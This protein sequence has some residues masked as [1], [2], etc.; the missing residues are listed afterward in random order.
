MTVDSIKM[1][2]DRG[3][4]TKCDT[5]LFK[6]RP[7]EHKGVMLQ[8]KYDSPDNLVYGLKN[9]ILD[10]LSGRFE[11]ELSAKILGVDYINNINENNIERVFDIINKTGIIGINTSRIAD[12]GVLRV[13]VCDNVHVDKT[14]EKYFKALSLYKFNEKYICN[15]NHKGSVIFE[16][17]RKKSPD[18]LTLYD[19]KTELRES[20][21]KPLLEML[22]ESGRLNEFDDVIRIEQ[23]VRSFEAMR[24][25]IGVK[26]TIE[27]GALLIDILQSKKRC[28]RD[29]LNTIVE[30]PPPT[31]FSDDRFSGMTLKQIEKQYGRESIIR[32]CNN[33]LFMVY[34][35]ISSKVK[36]NIGRYKREY[37]D[38]YRWMMRDANLSD[39]NEIDNCISEILMKLA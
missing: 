38:A 32:M 29:L 21:N 25:K 23:N 36:G 4:I 17:K 39:H 5:S 10:N 22:F 13:D 28:N 8:D 24:K 12:I 9:I 26:T 1:T 15:P 33:D 37:Q 35:F 7:V 30:E 31:L 20:R 2:G 3:L 6:H 27:N 34:E 11:I 16:S 18:R 19:K 14:K